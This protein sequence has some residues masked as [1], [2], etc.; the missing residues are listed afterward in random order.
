[1]KT[2]ALTAV[3]AVV[4]GT[5]AVAQTT[6]ARNESLAAT[7]KFSVGQLEDADVVDSANREVGD[8]EHVLLDAAGKPTAIVV[9]LDRMGPDKLVVLNLSEVTVSPEPGDPGDARVRTT[10]TKT[11]LLAR[12]DWKG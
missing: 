2:I 11:Q 9:E 3:F 4:A 7:A 5:A 8:V 1:M 10:L 6:I 12:P